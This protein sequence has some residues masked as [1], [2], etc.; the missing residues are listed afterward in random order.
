[1]NK[2]KLTLVGLN[3]MRQH[4][5]T[6]IELEGMPIVARWAINQDN[7]LILSFTK[8]LVVKELKDEY[9]NY[10]SLIVLLPSQDYQKIVHGSKFFIGQ[11]ELQ[12]KG[13][14]IK[15][16]LQDQYCE[17]IIPERHFEI[18]IEKK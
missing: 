6:K 4:R 18:V 7:D 11:K 10:S 9:A 12:I 2:I 1:M 3:G 17:I 15:I 8:F 14:N 13:L 5:S 16:G